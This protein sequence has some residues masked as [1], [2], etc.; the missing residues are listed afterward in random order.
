LKIIIPISVGELIDK[1]S[2]LQIKSQHTNNSYVLK[3]LKS[4][5]EIAKENEVYDD[6]CLKQLLDIN[7]LLWKIEDDLRVLEKHQ[8]F[9]DAFVNLA[10]SVYITNDV[11]S[12]IKKQI[13]E[14]YD[15]FYSEVKIYKYC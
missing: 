15:S 13:N 7:Q 6:E 11:R 12:S 5:T 10:R 3:E 8:D 1:I 9:G 2:I 4:L 14:K